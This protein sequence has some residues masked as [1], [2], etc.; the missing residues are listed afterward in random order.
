[1]I[2]KSEKFLDK[3]NVK[4]TKRE[5]DFKGYTSNPEIQVKDTESALKSKLIEL[6]MQIKGLKFMKT[7]VLLF[8]KM[9]SEDKTKY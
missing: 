7:L 6:L 9:E 1:M 4:I 3:K 8:K 5:H 2:Q